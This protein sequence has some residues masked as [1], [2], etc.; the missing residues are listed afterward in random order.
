M[1]VLVEAGFS[2][3]ASS[4]KVWWISEVAQNRSLGCYQGLRERP[5]TQNTTKQDAL[6]CLLWTWARNYPE[7]S[8]SHCSLRPLPDTDLR[9]TGWALFDWEGKTRAGSGSYSEGSI[10]LQCVGRLKVSGI[11]LGVPW[12]E[13]V[14]E[15]GSC[16]RLPARN[17]WEPTLLPGGRLQGISGWWIL[18]PVF[19]LFQSSDTA[20]FF[21]FFPHWEIWSTWCQLSQSSSFNHL[22]P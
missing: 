20:Q 17:T 21:F 5:A 13:W 16:P 7:P 1:C 18:F 15:G 11:C 8:I 6:D 14:D 2:K 3:T 4:P 10:C 19:N 12:Q 22:M 9:R